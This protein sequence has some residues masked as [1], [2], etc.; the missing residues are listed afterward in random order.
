MSRHWA[1]SAG[2]WYTIFAV[3]VMLTQ[4]GSVTREIINWDENTFML[5]GADILNGTLPYVERFDN[6]PPLIFF[7]FAGWMGMFGENVLSVRLLGDASLWLVAIVVFT[8]SRRFASVEIAGLTGTIYIALHAVEPGFH[9]TAGLPAMVFCMMALWLIIAYRKHVWAIYFAGVLVSLTVL[10]RSNLAYLAL[11]SGFWIL[12]VSLLQPSHS[13][14]SRWSSLVYLAGGLTPVLVLVLAYVRIDAVGTL[15]LASVD[16]A[17]NYAGQWSTGGALIE[18]LKK[19]A[20]AVQAAPII[21][22]VYTVLTVCGI[23]V[24]VAQHRQINSPKMNMHD[25]SIVWVF[26]LSI[27]LS[28]LKSGAVYTYYWQQFFPLTTLFIAF[29]LVQWSHR[30]ELY[31]AITLSLVV[32]VGVSLKGTA[33]DSL[34]VIMKPGYMTGQYGARDAADVLRDH[35]KPQDRIWALDRHLVL[36]YLDHPTVSPVVSHPSNITRDAIIITLSEA[37]YVVENELERILESLP[38]YLVS[39]AHGH[40]FYFENQNVIDDYI[41]Q[42]YHLLH[43]TS[44]T[45]IYRR[46]DLAP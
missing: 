11:F 27:Q 36:F 28:I 29:L 15:K 37:G 31:L 33:P 43:S 9:T 14:L 22:G 44:T 38:E 3:L 42:H 30:R 46:N 35:L 16:V 12:L 2:V 5:L 40:L 45:T 26:L 39:N 7:I 24:F 21:L 17:L 8:I 4:L 18:N 34:R 20:S 32:V 10:T 23:V 41:Q 25:W 6:K 19:W 1:K 13:R